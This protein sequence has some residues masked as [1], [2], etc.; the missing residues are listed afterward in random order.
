MRIALHITNK[1][2]VSILFTLSYLLINQSL[3]ATNVQ[4]S[5]LFLIFVICIL[6]SEIGHIFI[7]LIEKKIRKNNKSQEKSNFEGWGPFRGFVTL[8]QNQYELKY[9]YEIDFIL[10]GIAGSLYV[11]SLLG[12]KNLEIKGVLPSGFTQD[13]TFGPAFG[14]F[15]SY[16]L[17]LLVAFLGSLDIQFSKK[18]GAGGMKSGSFFATAFFI[19][20]IFLAFFKFL[21]D[22]LKLIFFQLFMIFL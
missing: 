4:P 13:K 1:A 11:F 16:F 12:L 15:F 6:F 22:S 21:Y 18:E 8:K 5:N 2:V 14:L 9:P 3:K 7:Y 20:I 17:F 10:L 19:L